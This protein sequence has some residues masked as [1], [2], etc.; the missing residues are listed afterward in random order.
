MHHAYKLLV[1]KIYA[2]HKEITNSVN[3]P[4]P[5]GYLHSGFTDLNEGL[6]PATLFKKRL[7]HR[8]F[9]V[10]FVKFLRTPILKNTS[11]RL[12]L[13]DEPMKFHNRIE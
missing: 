7:W 3:E 10:N 12:L 11:G 1:F 2:N 4:P 8:C 13:N 9:P 5:E 6:R